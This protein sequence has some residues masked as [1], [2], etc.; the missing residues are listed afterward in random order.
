MACQE[1]YLGATGSE[2]GCEAEADAG[3]AALKGRYQ[4]RVEIDLADGT[5]SDHDD[6]SMHILLLS[7][8]C[9]AKVVLQYPD[10]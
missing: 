6:F 5:C 1:D 9:T 8:S 3:C 4:T 7:V 10:Q 2:G